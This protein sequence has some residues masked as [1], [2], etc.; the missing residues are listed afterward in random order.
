MRLERRRNVGDAIF[1]DEIG[2]EYGV[3]G[4]YRLRS[5]Y[6]PIFAP[7][8]R[9][10]HAVAVEGLIEPHRAGRAGSPRAFF[11]SVATADR[12]FVETMCRVLHLRNFH[13]IGV[14]GLDL[15]FNYN[16]MINDHSGRALAEIRPASRHLSELGLAPG[17]L[18][19]EITEQAA[20][21]ALPRP[22]GARNAA[23]R[24]PHRHRRFRHRPL[25]R[26]AGEPAQA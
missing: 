3:H 24:H 15:F 2:I 18:V 21:D 5:A 14:D 10:L 25:D 4:E 20:D 6:Q 26:G 1:A 19:R 9:C 17:M 11:E 8:G 22:A 12:L 16:P 23:R 7:L 13:N